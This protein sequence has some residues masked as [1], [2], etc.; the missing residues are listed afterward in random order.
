MQKLI[1]NIALSNFHFCNIKILESLIKW[2]FSTNSKLKF[3]TF[4][5]SNFSSF[6]GWHLPVETSGNGPHSEKQNLFLDFFFFFFSFWLFHQSEIVGLQINIFCW[7]TLEVDRL[8]ITLN[9]NV[10]LQKLTKNARSFTGGARKCFFFRFS[11]IC[12]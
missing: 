7:E 12:L 9:M 11:Y 6:L 8:V 4:P 3:L 2:W 5:L 1:W 10:V